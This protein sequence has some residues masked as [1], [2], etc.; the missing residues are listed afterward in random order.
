MSLFPLQ[1]TSLQ[2]KILMPKDLFLIEWLKG[3]GQSAVTEN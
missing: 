3:R 1:I 2:I